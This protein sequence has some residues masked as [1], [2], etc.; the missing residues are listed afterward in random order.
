MYVFWIDSVPVNMK[1]I[2]PFVNNSSNKKK[3]AKQY[4]C[5]KNIYN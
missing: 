3:S 1:S 5:I 2:E 4:T